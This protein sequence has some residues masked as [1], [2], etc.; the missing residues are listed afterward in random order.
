MEIPILARSNTPPFSIEIDGT[1]TE[2]LYAADVISR[3]FQDKQI[4]PG[5]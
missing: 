5:Y 1:F 3:H 2:G 4:L